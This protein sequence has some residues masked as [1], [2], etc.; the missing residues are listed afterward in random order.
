MTNQAVVAALAA[1]ELFGT[2]TA[3][4]QD[5]LASESGVRRYASGQ[6]IFARGDAGATM[7][8]VG[9]G[10][11]TLSVTS[12]DGDEAV[13]A[14]LRP[15]Q[16]FGE[17]TLID[18]GAR[19]ATATARDATVLIAIPRVAVLRLIR[20]N[21][22]FAIQMLSALARLIRRV[23]DHLADMTL[24]DLRGRV[25]KFLATA[26]DSRDPS[27]ASTSA[28]DVDIKLTQ[29]DLA[30]IVGG[31]RQQVNRIIVDLERQGAIQRTG[32]RITAI[33]LDRL[34]TGRA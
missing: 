23:D 32:A 27:N 14:V 20:S 21:P 15:P 16:T 5:A 28:V 33:R 19:I 26:A 30:R 4:D 25:V 18:D 22:G 9:H 3:A 10:A 6:R 2:L 29:T 34:S 12:P 31:S 7:Y 11:V 1:S 24:L 13:L 8:L 17:L